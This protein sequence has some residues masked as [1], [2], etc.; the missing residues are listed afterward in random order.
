MPRFWR[1]ALLALTYSA[2]ASANAQEVTINEVVS[3]N[4]E[5]LVDENGDTPDWVE[6]KN[7]LSTPLD[8]AG[9]GLSDND[10]PFRWVFPATS[11]P[12]QG[13]VVVFASGKN[14][15]D[16]PA[17]WETIVDWGDE[18]RYLVPSAE[19]PA[20]WREPNFDDGAWSSG[21]TGI[22]YGDGDDRTEVPAGTISVYARITFELDDPSDVR[23]VHFD[24]DF[25]D[26]FVAYLNGVEIA[27]ENM[28]DR[29]R[30]PRFDETADTFT[31][32]R[33]IGGGALFHYAEEHFPTLLR[34]GENVL[35]V[36]LHN[37]GPASSDLT[38]I[39]F[40]TL[41]L[42]EA[43]DNS[44][45]PAEILRPTLSALHANFKLNADGETL[46]L[47]SPDGTTV[48][49]V[50]VGYLPTDVSMGRF[51]DG[52][53]EF[54]FHD[55]PTPGEANASAGFEAIGGTV[56]LSTAG[57]F[58]ADGVSLALSVSDGA[59]TLHVTTDGS[60]PTAS[61]P[62][63]SG[64]L[65]I[66]ETTVVRARVLGDGMIP[67][68]I[69]T[70]TFFIGDSFSLPVVS[71]ATDPANFFDPEI[72]IYV[73][74]DT[75]EQSFPH[76]G[77]NFWE[78][79]ERPV[80]LTFFEPDGTIGFSTEAGAKIFG[81]WSRGH[82]QR[83]LSFFARRRYGKGEFRHRI[84]PNKDIDEFESFILRNSGNDWQ[85]THFRDA[86][87]TSLLEDLNVDRQAYRPAILF[88]NGDYFGLMNLREKINEHFIA[89][90]HD[91]VAPDEVDLLERN[92][93]TIHGESDHYR[94]VVEIFETENV[95]SPDVY[96]RI[97]TMIDIDNFIDY[98]ASQIYFDNTDWPGNNIKYWRQR[99]EGGLWRWI[100]FDTDF[101]FGT[102]NV[103]NYTKNTLQF[104]LEPNGPGWPN[105]P[106]ATLMLRRFVTNDAFVTR[107]VNRLA[108]HM[109]TIFEPRKVVSRINEMETTIE[110]EMPAQR[111]RYGGSMSGWRS[112]VQ[113]MRTFGTQRPNYVRQH[114][115]S[116][117]GLGANANLSLD[118]TPPLGGTIAVHDRE[119]TGS[120]W[121]GRFFQGLPIDITAEASPGWRFVGWTGT[122]DDEAGESTQVTLAATSHEVTARFE[123]DCDAAG[124]VVINEINYNAPDTSDPGDWVE[125]HNRTPQPIDISGWQL[126]DEG[127]DRPYTIPAGT[128]IA[129]AGY[130]V[131]VSNTAAFDAQHPEVTERI[132]NLGYSLGGG[133]ERLEL[134]DNSGALVDT[135]EFDDKD[136]WPAAADGGG[137]TLALRN[138]AL[139]N[140][141]GPHW[142]ASSSGGTPGA[143][144]LDVL[145]PLE[146]DCIDPG[147]Q[148]VRG[149]CNDD[150]RPDIADAVCALNWL[151][152]GS[153][154]PRC[155]A[156]TNA[157]GDATFNIADPV[158]LLNYLFGGG[159]APTAPYPDCGLGVLEV[160]MELGCEAPTGC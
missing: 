160:D 100:L 97:A 104:A 43:P 151:F 11:I 45:G 158:Y 31:E 105:P 127:D 147:P 1:R 48:E 82:A 16:L 70:H 112:R 27:R 79:W 157:N 60:V 47:T 143:T 159:P 84:F 88:I 131:L 29:G 133:G 130:L 21:P 132:G 75:Y 23:Q 52:T 24:I 118:A 114:L 145:E 56:S 22:G 5:V 96:A 91:G 49:T 92:Q 103:S 153:V 125:L 4:A 51:P 25:D 9:Y 142:L 3:S 113:D 36:Q 77:A 108:T 135:L 78:D 149:D 71:L 90:N 30:P 95:S 69:E 146:V 39:P 129:G 59:G 57:G 28:I 117:F 94:S 80:H 124:D 101:G 98:Q 7:L 76:F 102:W 81:G 72:G 65:S 154:P 140:S 38:L 122:D 32:P 86:M 18:W 35:A 87:Q 109:S 33:L 55:E 150:G 115:R 85:N 34:S 121:R 126:R 14:R 106:W 123:L 68:R 2:V 10:D 152:V 93:A 6:L 83:S 63:Y 12:A 58:Y 74:G 120:P 139:E 99:A 17:H 156:A 136:P 41:G 137:A 64:P 110:P 15:T 73:L 111:A 116:T 67:G 37:T 19:P 50:E 40:L 42:D 141:Y 128:T 144:N 61:S 53:G 134:H 148:F 107:F 62:I 13:H 26:A 66:D 54:S 46:T 20:A 89:S 8:L 138:P 119:V 44:R 155:V